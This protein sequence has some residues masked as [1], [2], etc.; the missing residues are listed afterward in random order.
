MG[1]VTLAP[2][3]RKGKSALTPLPFYGIVVT[4]QQ[5]SAETT[6]PLEWKLLTNIPTTSFAEALVIIGYSR[7]RWQIEV[8]H[9][10]LKTG[11]NVEGCL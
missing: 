2:P 9:R 1:P 6:E 5:E 11:C 8:L 10:L 7:L 4:E 3:D